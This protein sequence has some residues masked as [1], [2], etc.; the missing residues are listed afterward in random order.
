MGI[1]LAALASVVSISDATADR[2]ML[3]ED[4][5]LSG[6][7]AIGARCY[8]SALLLASDALSRNG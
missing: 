7:R 2:E 1:L 3:W 5:N 6:A 8:S 4:E